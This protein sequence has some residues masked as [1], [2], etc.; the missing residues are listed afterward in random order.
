VVKYDNPETASNL[1]H[2]YAKFYS[3]GCGAEILNNTGCFGQTVNV[4]KIDPQTKL[5]IK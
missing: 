1:N 3:V 4:T 2:I 5:P